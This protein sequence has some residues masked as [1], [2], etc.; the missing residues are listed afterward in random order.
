VDEA[1]KQREL[2]YCQGHGNPRPS[3]QIWNS[4]GQFQKSSFVRF[5]KDNTARIPKLKTYLKGNTD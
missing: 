4:W 5:L 3:S 1:M 2:P